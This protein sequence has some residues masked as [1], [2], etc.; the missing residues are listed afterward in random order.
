M[1]QGFTSHLWNVGLFPQ[2]YTA[3]H[4]RKLSSS[5]SPSWDPKISHRNASYCNIS[6]AVVLKM[7]DY[8]IS[9]GS[10]LNVK[11]SSRRLKPDFCQTH[12]HKPDRL[13]PYPLRTE[14]PP[15]PTIV[16]FVFLIPNSP[17]PELNFRCF[18][19]RTNG[20]L[21]SVTDVRGTKVSEIRGPLDWTLAWIPPCCWVCQLSLRVV[22]VPVTN[23]RICQLW[24]RSDIY[25]HSIRGICVLWTVVSLA[26]R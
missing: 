21:S 26:I 8:K 2:H 16:L 17:P 7:Q 9:L 1:V 14:T 13:T 19:H 20:A 11:T 23:A 4:P 10:K 6:F 25:N 24:L 15:D 18:L 12:H 3:P 5:Y 22:F